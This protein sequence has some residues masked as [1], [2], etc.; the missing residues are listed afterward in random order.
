M[1]KKTLTWHHYPRARLRQKVVPKMTVSSVKTVKK[2]VGEFYLV[3]KIAS[4]FIILRVEKNATGKYLQ[5]L[6][7]VKF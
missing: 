3:M 1:L 7:K 2:W 5:V 4:S 6:K